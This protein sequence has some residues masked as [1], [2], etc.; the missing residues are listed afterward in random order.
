MSASQPPVPPPWNPPG[1]PAPP[2]G[3]PPVPP[4]PWAQPAGT[5]PAS[6]TAPAA[7]AAPA[8]PTAP[9]A[10]AVPPYP[11]AYTAPQAPAPGS[12]TPPQPYA[13]PYTA[14]VDPR[15]GAV[16]ASP[17]AR[18]SPTLGIVAVIVSGLA[19]LTVVVAAI[20]AFQIGLGSGA[21]IAMRP[22]AATWD[23]SLL[24]P[25]REW[26]LAGEMSFWIGTALG[27]WALVQGIV[28]IVTRRGR[29]AG[30][31]A[32]IVAIIAPIFFGFA[33]WLSLVAG[34]GAGSSIGG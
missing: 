12:A 25:V 3:V 10:P 23:M 31:V 22:N 30:I 24:T 19:A 8:S 9:T 5:G 32:V 6:P 14:P 2:P 15:F 13:A 33:V 21:E 17:P 16:L 34:I 1:Q 11:G 28:A 7:P 29:P 18:R 4:P 20:A 27:L 26:V